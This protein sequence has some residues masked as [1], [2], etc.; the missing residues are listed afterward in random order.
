MIQLVGAV[1]QCAKNIQGRR[2]VVDFSPKDTEKVK[3]FEEEGR[4]LGKV[5]FGGNSYC[6]CGFKCEAQFCDG[7]CAQDSP[8]IIC[9]L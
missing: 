5:M 9:L 8:K 7:K 2:D 6:M 1:E 4:Q 3:A